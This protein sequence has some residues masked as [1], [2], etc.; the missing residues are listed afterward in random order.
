[1]Q[2]DT[3]SPFHDRRQHTRYALP[4]M[5]TDVAARTLEE[6]TFDRS[7]HAYDLSLGGMRFELDRPLEPGSEIGVRIKL[8]AYG[9]SFAERRPIFAMARVVWVNEDD[10]EQ[11]GPIRMACVFRAFMQPGDRE[12]IE[13][14]LR[15][16]RYALAA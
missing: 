8:P 14:A 2:N 4:S 13:R 16:G 5:Y 7:G 11:G 12:R 15:S 9:L 6:N 1:M 3:M 10:L